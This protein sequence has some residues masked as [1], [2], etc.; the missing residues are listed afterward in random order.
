R[1]ALGAARGRLVRQLLTEGVILAACAAAGGLV[2][3][4]W[5]RNALALLVP[6][7]GGIALRLPGELDWRVV[8]LSAAV[9]LASTILFA[10]V[11]AILASSLDLANA[12][13]TQSGAVVGAR[14]RAWIRSTLVVVQVSLSC[15]LLVGAALLIESLQEV[16][17]ASPGFSTEGVLTTSV[18]LF[19]AGYD[20]PRARNFQD[21]LIDRIQAV[22]GVESAAFSRMTP[23]SYRN[24]SSA[25]VAVDGYEAPPD[26]QPTAEYNEVGPGYLA[27]VGIALVSGREFTRADDERALRVA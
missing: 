20:A 14:G 16:R 21:A 4:N 5:L 6:P 22:G 18:D 23:F 17:H 9:C 7:R 27:T 3:A 10:L 24:Y 12:L 11:P 2:V 15:V 1:L 25:S 8:A 19:T 26:Q 13:R